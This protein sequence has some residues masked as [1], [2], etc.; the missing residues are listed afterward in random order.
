MF[1]YR[2]T[3]VHEVGL[4]VVGPWMHRDPLSP[5]T[6]ET[7]CEFAKRC[8]L[9]L[10]QPITE[11]A[12]DDFPNKLDDNGHSTGETIRLD[13]KISELEELVSNKVRQSSGWEDEWNRA[14]S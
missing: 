9:A 14:L 12:S 13:R 3:L 10:E 7:W 1:S 4:S 8:M 11:R 5:E 6:A 2:N